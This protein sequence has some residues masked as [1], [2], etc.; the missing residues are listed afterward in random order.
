LYELVG[1]TCHLSGFQADSSEI[2][3]NT[4]LIIKQ[5]PIAQ[6]VYDEPPSTISEVKQEF[7]VEWYTKEPRR[8]DR[9]PIVPDFQKTKSIFQRLIT[10]LR[11]FKTGDVGLDSYGSNIK[12][13][14]PIDPKSWKLDYPVYSDNR[15]N[16]YLSK[17]DEAKYVVEANQ[18]PDNCR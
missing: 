12:L 13:R 18:S 9:G 6:E 17:H 2:K 7:G 8:I 1:S 3:L 10:S 14:I 11:L 5:V 16:Y 4:G 15:R